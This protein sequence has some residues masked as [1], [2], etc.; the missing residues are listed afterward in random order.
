ME[1]PIRAHQTLAAALKA[2]DSASGNC[3]TALG[4]TRVPQL[5]LI[6]PLLITLQTAGNQ[7][8]VE[9]C[10]IYCKLVEETLLYAFY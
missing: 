1:R 3:R 4:P 7:I 10:A 2:S 6:N 9:C 5:A 8:I